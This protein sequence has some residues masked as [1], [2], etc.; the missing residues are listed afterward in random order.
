MKTF[1]EFMS[2]SVTEKNAKFKVVKPGS[3]QFFD[4][5][6]DAQNFAGAVGKV[7]EKKKGDWISI[8]C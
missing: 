4:K 3:T 8:V 5:L 2:E 7:F 1:K 6:V